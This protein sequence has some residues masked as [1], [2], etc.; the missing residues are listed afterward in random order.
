MRRFAT[1]IMR[2]PLLRHQVQN[3]HQIAPQSYGS[4]LIATPAVSTS[5]ATVDTTQ[6][7]AAPVIVSTTSAPAAVAMPSA[8]SGSLSDYCSAVQSWLNNDTWPLILF[9]QGPLYERFKSFVA[10]ANDS[11]I[12]GSGDSMTSTPSVFDGYLKQFLPGGAPFVDNVQW[13]GGGN[14]VTLDNGKSTVQTTIRSYYQYGLAY[15]A[16]DAPGPL[17]HYLLQY[18]PGHCGVSG[19]GTV[20][21]P[22]TPTD[23]LSYGSVVQGQDGSFYQVGESSGGGLPFASAAAPIPASYLLIGAAAFVGLALLMS[24]GRR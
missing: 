1:P 8:S 5:A 18:I 17:V 24:G 6:Q 22:A 15:A 21:G 4:S 9:V 2:R 13:G 10:A 19:L 20:Y 3:Y 12:S 16:P 7:V 23:E 11:R 14:N